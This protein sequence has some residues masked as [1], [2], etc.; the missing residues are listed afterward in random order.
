MTWRTQT[1]QFN[2]RDVLPRATGRGRELLLQSLSSATEGMSFGGPI[3]D[4]PLNPPNRLPLLSSLAEGV[5][6]LPL[7]HLSSVSAGPGCPSG[8]EN[9]EPFLLDGDGSE[10]TGAAILDGRF[11]RH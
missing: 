3:S 9:P 2:E 7:V 11:E 10:S 1:K 8:V 4:R 6:L 5:N